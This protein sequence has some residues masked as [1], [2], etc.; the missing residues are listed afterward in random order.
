M[1]R[2]IPAIFVPLDVNLPHDDAIRAAGPWAELLYV[3]GLAYAKRCRPDGAIPKYDLAVVAIAI[4]G[5]A[6]SHAAALV[7]AGLW[8]DKGDH[9]GI[10]SWLKWNLSIEEQAAD[11]ER[12]RLGAILTNHKKHAERVESCPICRGEMSA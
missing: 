11:K 10:R 1:A 4:P 3:R 9:W 6:K 2:R 5:S 12:K 7:A 8:V